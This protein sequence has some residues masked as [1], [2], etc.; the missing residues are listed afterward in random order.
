MDTLTQIFLFYAALIALLAYIGNRMRPE[1]GMMYGAGTGIIISVIMWQ[2][3]GKKM[4]EKEQN[5]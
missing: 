5:C 4:V 1:H 2:M 3:Y